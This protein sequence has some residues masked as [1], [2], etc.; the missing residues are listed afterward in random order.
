MLALKEKNDKDIAQYKT[1]FM[2]L[3]RIIDH[4]RKLKEFMR[5]KGEERAELMEGEMTSRRKKRDEKDKG[6]KA[7][8]TIVV[9]IG[10]YLN[11]NLYFQTTILDQKKNTCMIGANNHNTVHVACQVE[12][13]FSLFLL[14]GKLLVLMLTQWKMRNIDSKL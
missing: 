8:E 2:E 11:T 6:D 14:C 9:S 3:E 4:E 13:Q 1:E 12:A 5:V 7:E 10:N